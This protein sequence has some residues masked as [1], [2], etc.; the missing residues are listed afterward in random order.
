MPFIHLLWA[1]VAVGIVATLAMTRAAV[2]VTIRSTAGIVLALLIVGIVLWLINTYV[3]MAHSINVILN[4]V[5]VIATCVGI[6][7]ATGLWPELTGAWERLKSRHVS[8]EP[9]A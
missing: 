3:P 7:R 6:L 4:V 2:P 9:H 1:L 5:V 8:H